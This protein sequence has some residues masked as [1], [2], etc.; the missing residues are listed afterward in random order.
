MSE[1]WQTKFGPR[2]VRHDPPTVAEALAAASGLTD[3][4][5]QQIEIAASLMNLPVEQVRTEAM[6]ARAGRKT[7]DTVAA[8][9]RTGMARAVIV[10]RKISRTRN[11]SRF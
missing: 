7:I 10:E 11:I 6:K 1:T 2:R 5:Q 9:G 4:T 3:D 8:R